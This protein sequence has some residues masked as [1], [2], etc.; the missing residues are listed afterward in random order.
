MKK[1]LVFMCLATSSVVFAADSV[2]TNLMN[3]VVKSSQKINL[4]QIPAGK[5]A[6]CYGVYDIST[7]QLAPLTRMYNFFYISNS[8]VDNGSQDVKTFVWKS[9]DMSTNGSN[10]INST[11]KNPM[12]RTKTLDNVSSG[13]LSQIINDEFSEN[14]TADLAEKTSSEFFKDQTSAISLT[15][16]SGSPEVSSSKEKIEYKIVFIAGFGKT[17]FGKVTPINYFIVGKK[18][19]SGKYSALSSSLAMCKLQNQTSTSKM[20]QPQP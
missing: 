2:T 12:V 6:F 20:V 14:I 10:E 9:S 1:F 19:N 8:S 13:Q 5:E 18:M 17:S 4:N 7:S 15:I 11:D 16:A 3:G